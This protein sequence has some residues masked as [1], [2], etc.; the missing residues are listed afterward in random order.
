MKRILEVGPAINPMHH[1]YGDRLS[2]VNIDERELQLEA[3]EDYTVLDQPRANFNHRIWQAARDTYGERV[4]F[5]HGDRGAMP[6]EDGSF[7][8]LVALGSHA[9][10]GV[11][12]SEFRRVLRSGGILRLG[13]P[14]QNAHDLMSG[15]GGRLKRLGFEFLEE[16]TQNYGYSQMGG[17]VNCDYTVLVF[18]KGS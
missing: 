5:V 4:H 15:W 18:R 1:R 13:T 7:D 16:E 11:I 6:F 12:V 3:N 14:A 17:C 8:E 10:E 9:K 2:D